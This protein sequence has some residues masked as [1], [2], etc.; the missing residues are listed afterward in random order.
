MKTMSILAVLVGAITV[1]NATIEGWSGGLVNHDGRS[2]VA[3]CIGGIAGL[4]LLLAGVTLLI[5]R[6][7]TWTRARTAA[8]VCVAGFVLMLV[9]SP[10]MSIFANMLGI[11]FP[12]ALIGYVQFQRGERGRL[13]DERDDGYSSSAST[14]ARPSIC[15]TP[16]GGEGRLQFFEGVARRQSN[17]RRSSLR[18][19]H[20]AGKSTSRR[21][22]V[23]S[24][25]WKSNQVR[26]MPV[27]SRPML[28]SMH[29]TDQLVPLF[30]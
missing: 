16:P 26:G 9:V 21:R 7:D 18:D 4:S 13:W 3:W 5:S 2:I 14:P 17:S 20:V 12:L 25:S 29:H 24:S 6:T 22:S 1:V 11:G 23:P 8:T 15:E 28:A 19:S 27:T 30:V 10:R